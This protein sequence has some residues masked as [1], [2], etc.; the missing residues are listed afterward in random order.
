ME[1]SLFAAKGKQ[2]MQMKDGSEAFVGSGD[3]FQQDPDE[4]IQTKDGFAGTQS[5]FSAVTT[6]YGYFFVDQASKKVFLMKIQ[7]EFF[8]AKYSIILNIANKINLIHY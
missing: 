6:R 3:I 8:K 4:I 2:Q 7:K 1:K 5:Q